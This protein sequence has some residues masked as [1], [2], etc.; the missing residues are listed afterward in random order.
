MPTIPRHP[1]HTELLYRGHLIFHYSFM[2]T[3]Q[4]YNVEVIGYPLDQNR[5]GFRNIPGLLE[6]QWAN[7]KNDTITEG[8]GTRQHRRRRRKPFQT[9]K[10]NYIGTSF[11][12]IQGLERL[13]P[14]RTAQPTPD[15]VIFDFVV[16]WRK[17]IFFALILFF[18]S[19][20]RCS[21]RSYD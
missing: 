18:S 7:A 21:A 10:T 13:F 1:N 17:F 20:S 2:N 9:W 5:T 8:S 3:T 11:E 14:R 6:T 16:R 4:E 12:T 19:H 15:H